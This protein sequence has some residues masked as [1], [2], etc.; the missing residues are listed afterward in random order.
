MGWINRQNSGRVI[1]LIPSFENSQVGG[2]KSH[3]IDRIEFAVVVALLQLFRIYTGT[4]GD[5]TAGEKNSPIGIVLVAANVDERE[6]ALNFVDDVNGMLF[7]D[8]SCICSKKNDPIFSIV[9]GQAVYR[10]RGR[11]RSPFR[12]KRR[13]LLFCPCRSCWRFSNVSFG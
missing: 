12:L 6:V 11:R 13:G 5:Q 8:K 4:I 1:V 7:G 2:A 9:F 10:R 3:A